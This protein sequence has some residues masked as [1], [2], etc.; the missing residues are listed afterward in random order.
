MM[1]GCGS[2]LWM[3]P[4]I[5]LGEIFNEKVDV[6]SYAMCMLE[7]VDCE[8]PWTSICSAGAV[9]LRVTRGDRPDLQLNRAECCS[10][11]KKLI[12]DCWDSKPQSRPSFRTIK[13]RVSTMMESSQHEEFDGEDDGQQDGTV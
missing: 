3:A 6:F 7:V 8:L 1:T 9:P 13:N 10:E 4:E 5:L 12:R 11:L 2:V